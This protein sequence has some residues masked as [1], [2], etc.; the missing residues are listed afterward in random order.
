MAQTRPQTRSGLDRRRRILTGATAGVAALALA[1]AVRVALTAGGEASPTAALNPA[2]LA[3][4]D[5]IPAAPM[6]S[7]PEVPPAIDRTRPATLRLDLI[8]EEKTLRLADGVSYTFWTFNGT[9]PGPMVRVREG[10]TV[11]VRLRNATGSTSPHSID[12]HAV[13]G[14]GGGAVYSQTA[15]GGTTAFV[16]KALKPGLYVYHCATAPIPMH[17]ANG[18]YGLIL[19]EP[20]RGMPRV[21]REYYVMQQEVY[22]AGPNGQQGLQAF[23]WQALWDERPQYVVFNGAVGALTGKSALRARAGETVRL[24]FG[25]GGPNLTSSFHVIGEIFDRVYNLASLS[26]APL[27]DVQTVTVPPGGAV[28]VDFTVEVP[29]RYTLVDHALGRIHKDAVGELVVEG[30][31]RPEIYRALR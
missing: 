13:T 8:T 9:V 7:P 6:A 31:D 11:V 27:T 19:V 12:L 30:Q 2:T 1:A 18:M 26:S 25:V 24:Y 5:A 17:I 29:G 16:F 15:A 21:D 23:D 4:V 28:A 3:D 14:T 20:A 10:D 22:T